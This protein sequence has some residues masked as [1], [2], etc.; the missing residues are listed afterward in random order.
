MN[1]VNLN[2]GSTSL[3][4]VSSSG[5]SVRREIPIVRPNTASISANQNDVIKSI[6]FNLYLHCDGSISS[7]EIGLIIF[8][9]F[10][11]QTFN[12]TWSSNSSDPNWHYNITSPAGLIYKVNSSKVDDYGFHKDH[13]SSCITPLIKCSGAKTSSTGD[14]TLSSSDFSFIEIT[15]EGSKLSNWNWSNTVGDW[16]GVG[17]YCVESKDFSNIVRWEV[18]S[19]GTSARTYFNLTLNYENTPTGIIRYNNNGNWVNCIPY[20]YNNGWKQCIPYYYNN[21]WKQL[22]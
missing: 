9:G 21:E 3:Y 8:K 7:N 20:Y 19:N 1:S 11:P 22:E 5:L 18:A 13:L 17:V 10:N 6:N 12:G 16:L 2:F 15:N 14:I 4:S